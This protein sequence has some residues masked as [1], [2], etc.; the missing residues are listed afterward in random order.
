MATW[1]FECYLLVQKVSLEI[2]SALEDK[3]RIPKRPC[4]SEALAREAR[5]G[6]PWVK[7]VVNYLYRGGVNVFPQCIAI[8]FLPRWRSFPSHVVFLRCFCVSF[9]PG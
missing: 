8:V 4:N 2:L 1:G 6:A 7:K 3:I 9:L 5:R